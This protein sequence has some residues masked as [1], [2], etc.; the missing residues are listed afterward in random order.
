M[1]CKGLQLSQA[2]HKSVTVC[3]LA[4]RSFFKSTNSRLLNKFKLCK[5]N[6]RIDQTGILTI[7]IRINT[8][9]CEYMFASWWLS[10]QGRGNDIT[11][12]GFCQ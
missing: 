6:I 2:S 9:V 12:L 5:A 11:I 4:L 1:A 3:K 8:D 7:V 10:E